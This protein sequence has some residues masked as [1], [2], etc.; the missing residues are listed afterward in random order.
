VSDPRATFAA[1]VE[2]AA[3]H[4]AANEWALAGGAWVEAA[5]VA[6]DASALPSARQALAAAGEA[7][8]RDDRLADAAR[9][10]RMALSYGPDPQEAALVQLRLAATCAELG[11][12]AEGLERLARAADAAPPSLR[13]AVLDTR[14]GLVLGHRRKAE[15]RPV[16]DAL[17]ALGGAATTAARF[18]RGQL[19]RLDGDL[20]AARAHQL[21]VI[22]VLADQPGAE[23]GTG[24]ARMELAECDLLDGAAA[25]AMAILEDARREHEAAQ[26]RG[27]ALRVEA[28][29]VRAAVE[30]GVAVLPGPLRDGLGYA[31]ERGLPMLAIELRLAAAA[32]L[33]A[34]D[35]GQARALAG[36]AVKAADACSARIAAGRGRAILAGLAE[37]AERELLRARAREDLADHVLLARRLG[38]G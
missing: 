27:L 20:A 17:E 32:A 11:A 9:A 2:A 31:E 12:A 19:A 7:F 36:A 33:A 35:P 5:R 37:G 15:A 13:G 4:Q 26:R 28:A 8:R 1:Y 38:G 23:A 6:V 3:A 18:R 34:R 25:S 24:A 14:V 22:R 21:E 29:R 30:A 16:V 10:L